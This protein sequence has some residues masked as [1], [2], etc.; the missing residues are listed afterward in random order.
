VIKGFVPEELGKG[1]RAEL[2]NDSP[3]WARHVAAHCFQQVSSRR[4]SMKII[5]QKFSLL[6]PRED[7]GDESSRVR[8]EIQALKQQLAQKSTEL[9]NAQ[10]RNMKLSQE[11]SNAEE[12]NASFIRQLTRF[13]EKKKAQ[14]EREKSA[15]LETKK[16]KQQLAQKSTEL[17]NA[18]KKISKLKQQL[19]EA[20]ETNESV[21]QQLQAEQ[22]KKNIQLQQK[23]SNASHQQH[24][25]RSRLTPEQERKNLTYEEQYRKLKSMGFKD[26]DVIAALAQ[27]KDNLEAATEALLVNQ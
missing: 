6:M 11:L 1:K 9:E 8:Q 2:P 3:E 22:A 19:S 23:M 7:I 25:Q 10:Q 26:E 18:E 20:E 12:S 13:N 4:P 17:E 27:H 14:D 24:Q 16:L 15:G 5:V 21:I